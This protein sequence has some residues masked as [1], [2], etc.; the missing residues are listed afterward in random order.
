MPN[1]EFLMW[2]DKHRPEVVKVRDMLEVP[3][4]DDLWIL[5]EQL[6]AVEAYHVR[7][8]TMLADAERLLIEAEHRELLALGTGGGP[9]SERKTHVKFATKTERRV[10]DVVKSLCNAMQYRMMLGMSVMKGLNAE[11]S[12]SNA[13]HGHRQG[14]PRTVRALTPRVLA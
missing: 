12:A 11:L 6:V 5:R 8:G 14:A 10:R 3:I 1:E 9:T 13:T 4:P 7:M 2:A